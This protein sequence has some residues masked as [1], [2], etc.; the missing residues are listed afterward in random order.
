MLRFALIAPALALAFATP[1]L[2]GNSLV[3]A[4]TPVA[5]AKSGLTVTPPAE[6]NRL[7]ARRGRNAETWTL[8]GDT[9]NNLTF[10]GG[11]IDGQPI[12]RE[13]SKKAKPLPRFAATMLASD[14]PALF[15]QSYR[16]ALDTALMEIEKVEPT[17]RQR[18][19]LHLSF[20]PAGGRRP[21]PRRGLWR[22]RRGQALHDYLRRP[23]DPL[24]RPRH[25]R[26]PRHRGQ[27]HPVAR[28]VQLVDK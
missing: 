22:D 25:R 2:A 13:I 19:A 7:G 3:V 4:G 8:D 17:R 24:F 15:E 12:F 21:P 1:V 10:Y 18:R 28:I 23:G 9:L 20:R 16:I 26:R 27:R 5:V 6:W 11:I 14:L